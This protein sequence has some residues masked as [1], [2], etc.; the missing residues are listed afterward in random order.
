MPRTTKNSVVLTVVHGPVL[1]HAPRALFSL[2]EKRQATSWL[3]LCRFCAAK[4]RPG[5]GGYK[6][7]GR[8]TPPV[9]VPYVRAHIIR[10]FKDRTV[11]PCAVSGIRRP[12]VKS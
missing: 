12:N 9:R 10:I 8:C 7:T 3:T 6:T 2:G 4:F 1:P 11:G 5:M